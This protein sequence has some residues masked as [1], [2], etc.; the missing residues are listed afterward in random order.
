MPPTSRFF[1]L[2]ITGTS[3]RRC[4]RID[5]SERTGAVARP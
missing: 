5:L 1:M 3:S 4:V 2:F